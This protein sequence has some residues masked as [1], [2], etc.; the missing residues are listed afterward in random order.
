MIEA[1]DEYLA[2]YNETPKRFMWTKGADMILA[3]V[4]RCQ[5]ASLTAHWRSA[6]DNMQLEPTRAAVRQ[7][8]LA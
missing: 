7:C 6:R 8:R 4:D 1:I 5:E 3:K 2:K